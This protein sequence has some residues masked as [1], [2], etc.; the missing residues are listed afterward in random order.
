MSPLIRCSQARARSQ[1]PEGV[2]YKADPRVSG[3][4][5]ISESAR[6]VVPGLLLARFPCRSPNPELS[7]NCRS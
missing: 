4:A 7:R 3:Q 1:L 5:G 6:G 2:K